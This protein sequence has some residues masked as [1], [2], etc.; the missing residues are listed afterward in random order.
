MGKPENYHSPQLEEILKS[1]PLYTRF[2]VPLEMAYLKLM[3]PEDAANDIKEE[4][5]KAAHEWA[6]DLA[7]YF[8][9]EVEEWE[10]DGRPHEK[11]P[12]DKQS[13]ED[14]SPTPA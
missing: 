6:D 13:E 11:G 1:I 5:W 12:D 2:K 4:Q 8:I 7:R 3:C 10:Q 14:P 9:E